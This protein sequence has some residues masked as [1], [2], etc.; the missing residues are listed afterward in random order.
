LTLRYEP[1]AL[2]WHR[3]RRSYVDLR[4]QIYANGRS[5]G[6]YLINTW[7]AGR[8][9]GVVGYAARWMSGWVVSRFVRGLV[10]REDFPLDLLWAELQGALVAPA[11]YLAA[12]KND[13]RIR[14]A[15][16]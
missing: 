3:H 16:S 5:Y 7:R 9:E 12:V 13:R 4:R 14:Q 6:V 15:N 1:A 10:G 2:I 8:T 11:A